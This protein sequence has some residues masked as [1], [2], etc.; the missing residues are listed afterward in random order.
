MLLI[1]CGGEG[2]SRTHASLPDPPT[3]FILIRQG[4]FAFVLYD[5]LAKRVWAARDAEVGERRVAPRRGAL[6]R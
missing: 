1:G 3:C 2:P 4:S 6:L 5:S